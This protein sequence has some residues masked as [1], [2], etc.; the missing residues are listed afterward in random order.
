MDAYQ[1]EK[2]QDEGAH[3]DAWLIDR[4]LKAST[5]GLKKFSKRRQLQY[6]AKHRLAFREL[7][8][9][10]W[11]HVVKRMK[12]PSAK[13]LKPFL[14]LAIHIEEF[15]LDPK[16]QGNKTWKDHLDIKEVMLATR[17]DPESWFFMVYAHRT[18]N[19]YNNSSY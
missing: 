6:P 9:L 1:L 18:T 2:L 13:A 16:H 4:L 17:L 19:L 8:L 15:W 14:P 12:H 5:N 3:V 7:G 11:F 10:M